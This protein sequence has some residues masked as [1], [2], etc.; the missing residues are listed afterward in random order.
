MTNLRHVVVYILK[1]LNCAKNLTIIMFWSFFSIGGK[2]NLFHQNRSSTNG[3]LCYISF[4]IYIVI[5]S[6]N[7]TRYDSFSVVFSSQ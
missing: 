1:N 2:V 6:K 4:Y 5:M 7:Q 3:F